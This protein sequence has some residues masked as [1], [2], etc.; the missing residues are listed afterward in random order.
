[1]QHG[2][3]KRDEP[4][5]HIE[6]SCLNT[7]AQG[8]YDVV[9]RRH[10]QPARPIWFAPTWFGRD[11]RRRSWSEYANHPQRAKLNREL[12]PQVRQS[13]QDKL[14][15]SMM[16]AVFTVLDKLPLSP[17]G[18]IDRHVLAQLPVS[19]AP[20]AQEALLMARNPVEKLL[21]NIWADVLNLNHVGVD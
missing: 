7:D 8:V 17:T 12:I 15:H 18:K 14:P 19:L 9:F 2:A 5:Y 10:D 3:S 1:L 11:T 4:E 13:L 6:L 16:P 21:A 20:V